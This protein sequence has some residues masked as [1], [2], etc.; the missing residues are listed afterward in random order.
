MVVDLLPK[1]KE[2]MV[3]Q[4][5]ILNINVPDLPYEQLKGVKITQ[6]GKRS[7]AAEIVKTN[8]PRGGCVYWLG[9]NGVAID[10]REGTD[11]A[12]INQDCVSITPLQADMTAYK[13]LESLQSL[14]A[15]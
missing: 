10:E 9:A 6:L 15:K 7:P 4:R 1:L 13:T 11:F 2:G 12:A 3:T 5:E 8:D 14:C